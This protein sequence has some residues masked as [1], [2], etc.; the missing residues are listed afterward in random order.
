MQTTGLVEASASHSSPNSAE[1]HS[2]CAVLSLLG[3]YLH[4]SPHVQRLAVRKWN[5][6]PVLI[7][8]LWE[9]PTQKLTLDMVRLSLCCMTA[10]TIATLRLPHKCKV[11]SPLARLSLYCMTAPTTA[12]LMCICTDG[13]RTEDENLHHSRGQFPLQS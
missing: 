9:Q 1:R 8:L 2:R 4:A 5:I 7:G 13:S 10:P 12:G 11:D 3:I 6:V